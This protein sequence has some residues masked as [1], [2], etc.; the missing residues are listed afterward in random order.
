MSDRLGWLSGNDDRDAVPAAASTDEPDTRSPLQ[1][2][3][4]APKK[5]LSVTDLV[6]PAWCE[7]QYAYTLSSPLGRKKQTAAMKQGSGV[8]RKLEDQ[9]HTTVRVEV[10]TKEDALGLRFWNVIQGLRTLRQTGLTRELEVWGTVNGLVVNGVIDE[11]SHTCPDAEMEESAQGRKSSAPDSLPPDQTAILEFFAKQEDAKLSDSRR[12]KRR[13][14]SK[15]IYIC[16]VKTRGVASLPK[17]AAFRPTKMQLMIYHYLF[18]QMATNSV[19]FSLLAARHSLDMNVPFSD[20]LLAQIGNLDDEVYYDASTEA[21]QDSDSS[22]DQNQDSM[23]ILLNHNS[24]A[25]LWTLMIEEFQ[26]TLPNGTSDIG[27]V[28][29][30]E[31]RSRDKGHVLGVN[32][33]VMDE[34]VLHMYLDHGMQWWQGE[35]KPAGVIVEEAYKCRSCD[36]AEACTWRLARVEEATHKAR[37]AKRSM[38]EIKKWEV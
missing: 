13:A 34:G 27:T 24:L 33:F 28:L 31:Y 19:D 23:T 11:L 1:R 8:H 5:A 22:T 17:G 4:T 6:S 12:S 37:A 2:F 35:R 15:K 30:A 9:V 26:R 21:D 25:S 18:S 7:L 29:K 32:T 20:S 36:F 16:D 3:R 10:Q 14:N 38:S